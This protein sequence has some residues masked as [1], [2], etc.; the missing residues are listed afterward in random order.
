MVGIDDVA[1]ERMAKDHDPADH[2][3]GL[4]W[5]LPQEITETHPDRGPDH[6][7]VG[8]RT[9]PAVGRE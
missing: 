4:P 5:S 1:D 3:I 9:Q 6:D 8:H 7:L 2:Q